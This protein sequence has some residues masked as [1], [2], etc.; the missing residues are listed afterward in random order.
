MGFNLPLR[1]YFNKMSEPTTWVRPNDWPVIT[2]ADNEVQFLMSDIDSAACTVQT[3]FTRT[4]GS[5]DIIIDWGDGTTNTVTATTSTNTTH[6]YTPGTGTPCSRGYTTFKIRV[7]FTGTGVS[8]LGQCRISSL[9]PSGNT[10]TP[11]VNVGLLEIYYGDGNK[12][13]NRNS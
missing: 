5:Q 2:D 6:Q 11:Y 10:A 1:N 8:S 7:Y 3:T 13:T 9:L 12:T 4:T